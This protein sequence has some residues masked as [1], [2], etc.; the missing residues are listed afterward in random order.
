MGILGSYLTLKNKIS[1][2]DAIMSGVA[3]AISEQAEIEFKRL[4][5][6]PTDVES[7]RANTQTLT[8]EKGFSSPNSQRINTLQLSPKGVQKRDFDS[9][10]DL[11]EETSRLSKNSSYIAIKDCVTE[12]FDENMNEEKLKS[13]KENLNI[14]TENERFSAIYFFWLYFVVHS[15]FYSKISEKELE[16]GIK[17]LDHYVMSLNQ[18][19]GLWLE[20]AKS[21]FYSS[22][23][24][25]NPNSREILKYLYE[26]LEYD[27]S[28]IEQQ[29][30]IKLTSLRDVVISSLSETIAKNEKLHI[31]KKEIKANKRKEE[32]KQEKEYDEVIYYVVVTLFIFLFF[33]ILLIG[34]LSDQH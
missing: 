23:I 31:V 26:N 10:M 18:N 25:T 27:S 5:S 6:A 19:F 21:K 13:V 7:S 8:N 12:F 22:P 29:I 32:E 30:I 3:K 1:I 20:E 4:Y 28:M 17:S 16:Y 24:L 14:T 15:Y 11:M 33:I 2:N 9:V 34:I